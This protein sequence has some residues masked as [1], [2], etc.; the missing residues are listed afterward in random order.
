MV[1]R[2][3]VIL[4]LL[5]ACAVVLPSCARNP[6]SYIADQERRQEVISILLNDAARRQEV[7]DRLVGP[8]SERAAIIDRI[9]KD[10]EVAGQLLKQLMSE[11]RGKALVASKV[12]ADQNGARTFIR[13]LMLTGVM[14]ASLTQQQAN[15]VG[16]GEPFSYGNQRRTM[17]DLKRIGAQID[18]W[19][20]AKGRYPVCRDF[21]DIDACLKKHLG[22]EPLRDVRVADAWGRPIQYRSDAEGSQYILVSYATDGEYDE[23]GKVGPTQSYDCDIVFSNGDFI[24][25]PG[26]IRKSEIR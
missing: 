6:A 15:A 14:G 2:K 16:L 7:I 26:I 9:V 5:V 17:A 4:G 12:A 3:S 13:M 21:G 1:S 18:G 11:D 20:K 22:D 8:P 19:A 10:D 23:L 25:W 24:Q